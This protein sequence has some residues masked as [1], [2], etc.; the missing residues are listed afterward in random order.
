MHIED[1]L[2]APAAWRSDGKR[3]APGSVGSGGLDSHATDSASSTMQASI[4]A[5]STEQSRSAKTDTKT[6]VA[7]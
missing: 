1:A 2:T 5:K 3:S 7:I 4:S 6:R